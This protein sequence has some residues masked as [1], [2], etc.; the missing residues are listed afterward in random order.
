LGQ[1]QVDLNGTERKKKRIHTHG[2]FSKKK[3]EIKKVTEI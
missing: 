3:I 1:G 2:D